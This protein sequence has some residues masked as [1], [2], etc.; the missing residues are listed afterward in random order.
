MFPESSGCGTEFQAGQRRGGPSQVGRG[1]ICGSWPS[2]LNEHK[3]LSLCRR[4]RRNFLA[5]RGRR[6]RLPADRGR[7]SHLFVSRRRHHLLPEDEPYF[8]LP[9]ISK[10]WQG[11]SHDHS[12]ASNE[13]EVA[14]DDPRY[15]WSCR[16]AF[17]FGGRRTPAFDTSRT[18]GCGQFVLWGLSGRPQQEWLCMRLRGC[19]DGHASRVFGWLYFSPCDPK[20]SRQ[21][22]GTVPRACGHGLS[23]KRHGRG[24]KRRT[25][26]SRS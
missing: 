6:T 24:A 14:T 25:G 22:C 1:T 13:A 19:R 5:Q 23:W 17:G 21:A 18:L 2:R 8:A 15:D 12:E 11:T 10:F 4:I 20:S 3:C 9:P 26:G 16:C 7:I